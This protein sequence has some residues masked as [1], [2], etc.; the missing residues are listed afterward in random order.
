MRIRL[1]IALTALAAVALPAIHAQDLKAGFL[2]LEDLG[3]ATFLDC[4]NRGDD[5]QPA[6]EQLQRR[7]PDRPGQAEHPGAQL[8]PV[9]DVVRAASPARDG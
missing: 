9:P 1:F 6:A 8:Q 2:L 7:V 5:P 3:E 4:L